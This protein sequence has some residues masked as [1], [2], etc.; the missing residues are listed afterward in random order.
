[1]GSIPCWAL[2]NR[3]FIMIIVNYLE[4]SCEIHQPNLDAPW[5]L[6]RGN[7]WALFWNY[8]I[9][10]IKKWQVSWLLTKIYR[11]LI[12]VKNRG[13]SAQVNRFRLCDFFFLKQSHVYSLDFI[14]AIKVQFALIGSLLGNLFWPLQTFKL[15]WGSKMVIFT[16]CHY[17]N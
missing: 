15:C 14:R 16:G 6:R 7:S 11:Y 3:D 2:R 9:L 4:I 10:D 8:F 5:C 1:M 13:V 17:F 12:L